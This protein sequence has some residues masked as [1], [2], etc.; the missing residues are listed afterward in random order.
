MRYN[1]GLI[2]PL[3]F[4]LAACSQ[5]PART[6]ASTDTYFDKDSNFLPVP[7]GG[8]VQVNIGSLDKEEQLVTIKA[9][10]AGQQNEKVFSV[11]VSD[12]MDTAELYKFVWDTATSC[13]IA[14]MKKNMQPRYFHA[15]IKEG[16][17]KIFQ[18]GTPPMRI[19]DYADR[20]FA[21]DSIGRKMVKSLRRRVQSGSVLEDL[22]IETK[23]VQPDHVVMTV[24]YGAVSKTDTLLVPHTLNAGVLG[25]D[26][27]EEVA[28]GVLQDGRFVPLYNIQVDA[29]Q[30]RLKQINK[31]NGAS[32]TDRTEPVQSK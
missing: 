9:N 23:Q 3:L 21:A 2:L 11:P 18:V 6:S 7:A 16:D 31:F 22:V 14:V 17:L 10:M 20:L 12:A 4:I 28:Y 8:N 24:A 30:L 19:S 25:T 5:Q 29:G 32:A 13:Y 15:S 1:L 26:K 27:P